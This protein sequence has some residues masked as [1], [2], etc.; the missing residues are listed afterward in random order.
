M[1]SRNAKLDSLPVRWMPEAEAAYLGS[2]A[3]IAAQDQHAADLVTQ[4]VERVL[5]VIQAQP[6]I[7]TLAKRGGETVFD[8]EHRPCH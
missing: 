8:S 5:T 3:Y 6:D 2:L 1:V 7:G 4:R